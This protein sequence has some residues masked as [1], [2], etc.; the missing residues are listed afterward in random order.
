MT[1]RVIQFST[2]N[3]GPHALRQL[4][5][6]PGFELVGVHASSPGKV[7]RDAAELCGLESPTE[8]MVTDDVDALV[9]READC[10]VY[11]SQVET[12]P[13]QAVREL[14]AFLAAG[15]NVVATSL[16]WLIYPPHADAWLTGPLDEAW[17]AGGTTM[18]VNGADS[19]FSGDLPPLAALSLTARADS[20]LVQEVCDYGSYD[21]A[22]FTGVSFGFGTDPGYVPMLFLPGVLSS[23]WGGPVRLL[24]DELGVESDGL[25][26]R[27]EP[28][29]ATAPIDCTMMRIEPG[30]VAAVR[31]AVEGIVGGRL[32][33]VMEHVNRLTAA[34]APDWP[35][36][37][38]GRPGVH[39]VVVSGSPGGGD[40]HPPRPRRVRPQHRG[41]DRHRGQGSQRHRRGLRRATRAGVSTGSAGVPG[42]RPLDVTSARPGASL[43]A[44][45]TRSGARVQERGERTRATII[46]ETVR[47]IEEEGFAATSASHIAE[48]AGVTRG[49]PGCHPVSLR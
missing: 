2:G 27:V 21:D 11:M 26:E 48:R 37:P 15:T 44:G 35:V 6:R 10:V 42:R 4:I 16:V 3:V 19:G 43:R 22:E 41:G 32:A 24:A 30:K 33:I 36:P 38:E 1:T 7:G 39:R 18:C 31:F 5:E 45:P 12:R 34:A 8:V 49:D 14:S 17:R 20:V 40:E 9:A 23:I 46:A 47:C 13:Q 25:R 29:V 28:W